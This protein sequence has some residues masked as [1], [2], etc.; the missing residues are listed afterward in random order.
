MNGAHT[1]VF[2]AKMGPERLGWLISLHNRGL[3]LIINNGVIGK[4]ELVDRIIRTSTLR[5]PTLLRGKRT[6]PF[7]CPKQ[8]LRPWRFW[9]PWVGWWPE[10][11]TI[12]TEQGPSSVCGMR[13]SSPPDLTLFAW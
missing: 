13:V 3:H 10:N 8:G 12:G 7:I 4:Y 5:A 1:K 11:R 2:R 9:T 6:Y